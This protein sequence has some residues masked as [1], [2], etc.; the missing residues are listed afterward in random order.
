[1]SEKSRR[2]ANT[3]KPAIYQKKGNHMTTFQIRKPRCFLVY[4][5]A[6]QGT[7]P[8]QANRQFNEFV[9][10]KGLPLVLFHDHFIG[11]PGGAAVF[12]AETTQEQEMLVNCVLSHQY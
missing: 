6:P 1:M 12:F 8:A 7:L 2:K 10:D 5:L 9:A 11:Q 3:V 4:A